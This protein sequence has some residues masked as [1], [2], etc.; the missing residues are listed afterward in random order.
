MLLMQTYAG[1]TTSLKFNDID[2]DFWATT[3]Q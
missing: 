2:V 3:I 1:H